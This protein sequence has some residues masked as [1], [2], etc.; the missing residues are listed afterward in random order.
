MTKSKQPELLES[1]NHDLQPVQG[2]AKIVLGHCT[3]FVDTDGSISN[4]TKAKQP[5][6]LETASHNLHCLCRVL[7]R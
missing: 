6:L 4:I 3:R 2:A 5:Q 7:L 1:V